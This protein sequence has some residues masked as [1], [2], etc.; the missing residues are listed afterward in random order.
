MLKW[1]LKTGLKN[2]Y[3]YDLAKQVH[4][5][6][7]TRVSLNQDIQIPEITPFEFQ[8]SKLQGKRINLLVPALSEKHIFGGI[9]TALRLFREMIKAFPSVRI[10]VTD[11]ASVILPEKEFFSDWIVQEIGTEDSEGNSIV[12]SGNRYGKTLPIREEDYFV[13]TAWWTAF[14]AFR[15]MEWQQEAYSTPK[16]KMTYLVQDFEP[17]F[18]PWSTRFALADSTYRHPELT[19]PVFNTGLLFDFFK[20][21]NYQFEQAYYFEPKFNPV[22]NDWRGKKGDTAKKKQILVYGRPSVERNL[23]P[24]IVQTIAVWSQKYSNAAEWEVISA[25]EC[26]DDIPVNATTVLKSVGK[27]SLE[28]YATILSETSIGVSLMLSPHPSY[29][30]LEM[31]MY[32]VKVVTNKYANKDLSQLSPLIKS[33]DSL[34]PNVLADQLIELCES[35]STELK[36][37]LEL[38]DACDERCES[39]FNQG[40]GPEFEFVHELIQQM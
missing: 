31:A 21:Q 4:Q 25:G 14:N 9:A 3:L 19:I 39:L 13:A 34:D 28:E 2:R 17:G 33:V 30:P 38:K 32:G 16:R 24:L 11:E 27:V 6:T 5:E 40:T 26:H 29:P 10:I 23:F 7:S 35:R 12:V 36:T 37:G 20:Q 1:F 8:S 15:A 18:Y 22:L